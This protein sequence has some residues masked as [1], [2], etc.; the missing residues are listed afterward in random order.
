MKLFT[1]AFLLLAQSMIASVT[2][3]ETLMIKLKVS[4]SHYELVDSWLLTRSYPATIDAADAKDLHWQLLDADSNPLKEGWIK[5]PQKSNGA[6]LEEEHSPMLAS[7]DKTYR[8]QGEHRIDAADV[9]IRVP[10]DPRIR[11]LQI[12]R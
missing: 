2:F 10:Y 3:S 11:T 12:E 5:D 7:G 8:H 4:D 6:F 1:T 9:L